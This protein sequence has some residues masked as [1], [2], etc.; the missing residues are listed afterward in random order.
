MASKVAPKSHTNRPGDR[1][2]RITERP[3]PA[4]QLHKFATGAVRDSDADGVAMHLLCPT[5][6]LRVA[7]I[8]REG[9]VKYGK[10]NWLKGM[11]TGETL[12]HTLRHLALF[13]EGNKNEDHLAKAVWGIFAI[14]HFQDRC[15]H[16]TVLYE[17]D[18]IDKQYAD[19]FKEIKK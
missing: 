2:I 11:D 3:D 4:K 16:S 13:M 17:N 15:L 7:A 10:A 12:N 6:L 8:Y 1:N 5:A 18:M 14:M 19:Q 9:E